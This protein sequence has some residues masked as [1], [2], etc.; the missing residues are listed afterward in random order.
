MSLERCFRSDGMTVNLEGDLQESKD[1]KKSKAV[2]Q[3]RIIISCDFVYEPFFPTTHRRSADP[4]QR[5]KHMAKKRMGHTTTLLPNGSVLV[6]GGCARKYGEATGH[7]E[8][9]VRDPTFS[10]CKIINPHSLSDRTSCF[11]K[12]ARAYHSAVRLKNGTVLITGG[13]GQEV[14]P[15]HENFL[16][17]R[18]LMKVPGIS[19]KFIPE[20]A[21]K[22][23][24]R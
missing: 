24:H 23:P 15:V 9:C 6:A 20:K 21:S 17:F 11:M 2:V 5:L 16:T 7:C 4:W 19:V 12:L 8:V 13:T 3:G 10:Y 14:S 22:M 18:I 1:K